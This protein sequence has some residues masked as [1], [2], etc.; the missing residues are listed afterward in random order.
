M[1]STRWSRGKG[2]CGGWRRAFLILIPSG[3][4]H[5]RV[6]IFPTVAAIVWPSSADARHA[7][8]VELLRCTTHTHHTFGVLVAV[9]LLRELG[10]C[11]E[12]LLMCLMMMKLESIYLCVSALHAQDELAANSNYSPYI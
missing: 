2:V 6:A 12:A 1:T 8:I 5:L 3:P 4:P 10:D 11:T 7:E 9:R